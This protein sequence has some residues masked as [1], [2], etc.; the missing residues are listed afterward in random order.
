MGTQMWTDE[1]GG[2]YLNFWEPE[3]GRK[4]DDVMGYQL[5]GQWSAL[6]HG[7]PGVFREDRIKNALG[8]ITRCNFALTPEVGAA[9]FCRPDGSPLTKKQTEK[10]ETIADVTEADV[11]HYGTYA[12][13]TA[14]VVILGMTYMQADEYDFG[15]DLV[16]KHWETLMCRSGHPWDYPNLVNGKTGERIFGTDY[17]QGMMLWALPAVVEGKTIAE[18]S[19]PDGLVDRIIR[20][21]NPE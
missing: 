20:A 13:F 4:S 8:T 21:A 5:D 18:F 17:G 10:Q 2:Y 6:S 12:M 15:L 19:A 1:A 7:L 9:N 16:R 11:A 14:E 3:T